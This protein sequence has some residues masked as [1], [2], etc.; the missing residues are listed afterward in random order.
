MSKMLLAEGQTYLLNLIRSNVKLQASLEGQPEKFDILAYN[1]GLLTLPALP[2]P[3]VFNLASMRVADAGVPLLFGHDGNKIVGQA[4]QIQI[5]QPDT[6]KATGIANGSSIYRTEVVANARKGYNWQVSIGV[7]SLDIQLVKEGQ[8][9]VVNAQTF[10]GPIYVANTNILRE[11]SFVGV[12]ADSSTFAKLLAASLK[13]STMTYEEWLASLGI[14]PATLAEAETAIA[15]RIYDAW[16]SQTAEAKGDTTKVEAAA[17][18]ASTALQAMLTLRTH[19]IP[20]PTVPPTV[21]PTV[22]PPLNAGFDLNAIR[23]QQAIEFDRINQI[24]ALNAQYNNPLING[25]SLAA[26]AIR[27]GWDLTRVKNE[28]ELFKLRNDRPTNV[29]SGGRNGGS[30]GAFQQHQILE[31]A[32]AQ[33]G[34]LKNIEKHFGELLLDAAHKQY[35]SRIGLKEFLL[36]AAFANGYRGSYNVKANLREI[37]KAV[38]STIDIPTVL[39]NNANKYMMEGFNAVDDSWREFTAVGRVDDFKEMTGFR[40][41]GAFRFE[42]LPPTGQIKHAT[43]TEATYGNKADTFAKTVGIPR[44]VIINDDMGY[45]TSVPRQL[46]RGGAL[47]VVHEVYTEFLDNSTFFVAGNNNVTTGALSIASVNTALTAFRTLKDENGDYVM[48]R[49]AILLV[50]TQLEETANQLYVDTNRGGG[51]TG[52]FETNPHKGKYTPVVSPYLSDSR[53]TGNSSTAWYLL[54]DPNDVPVIEIVFLD[55]VETPTVDTA[56]VDFDQLGI[57]MRGYFDFGVRKQEPRGGVR[58]TGV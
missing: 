27:D 38:F 51:N 18:T 24:Q 49:P 14:D 6:I 29:L 17:K 1:G 8:R 42:I 26:T 43:L 41:V 16:Q 36:E 32:L 34:N 37:L 33:A 21:P 19:R 35:K 30:T 53:F 7:Q 11:I 10:T 55:G 45:L 46:G 12:G 22:T 2:L 48:A 56:E 28:F 5:I 44:T 40:G 39:S 23:Q 9:V 58:S 15:K 31:C 50:P 4:E 57:Q 3:V 54:A 13:G 47:A 25:Q 20:A 52:D